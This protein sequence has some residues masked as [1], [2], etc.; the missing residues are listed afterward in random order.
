M[1]L[2]TLGL[3]LATIASGSTSLTAQTSETSPAR[4]KPDADAWP[5]G[6]TARPDAGGDRKQIK[7]V[8]MEPGYHLT[9]G[10][11]T[12]LYRQ[13]DQV[14]EPFH[15]MATF[16]QMKK[17]KHA[18]GYGLFMGGQKLDSDGQAYTYFLVRADGKFTIKRRQGDKVA[19]V[20]SWKSHPAIKPAD[21]AGKAT[22]ALEIDAKID[23][24]RV[25][26]K[27]NGQEVHSLA[28]ARVQT[29]GVVGLRVN[30]N[31]DLHVEEFAVH[32]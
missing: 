24:T 8:T 17:L 2:K 12:I 13:E 30:H 10:P 11:A 5:A 20:V 27:V 23:P 22:N 1:N 31:L 18:E 26:F 28:A 19:E 15:S 3:L 29:K 9:L 25:S 6:W 21:S 14:D 4:A 7:F 16:H 32:K